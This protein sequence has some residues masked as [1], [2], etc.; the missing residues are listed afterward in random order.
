MGEYISEDAEVK[1]SLFPKWIAVENP[2]ELFVWEGSPGSDIKVSYGNCLTT[3]KVISSKDP[4]I[5]IGSYIMFDASKS[6]SFPS[7]NKKIKVIHVDFI[8]C[9]AE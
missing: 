5:P 8:V 7:E 3:G 2:K 6:F 9:I 4:S 1:M